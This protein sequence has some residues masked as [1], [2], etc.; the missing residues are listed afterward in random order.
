MMTEAQ[1]ELF[2]GAPRTDTTGAL[3]EVGIKVYGTG[4]YAVRVERNGDG[5]LALSP[6]DARALAWQLVQAAQAEEEGL[7]GG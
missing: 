2:T 3:A 1:L 7:A 4:K 6:Q 5:C